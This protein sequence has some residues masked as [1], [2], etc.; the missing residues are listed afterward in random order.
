MTIYYGVHGT[1]KSSAL[2]IEK[3]TEPILTKVGYAGTGF[4]LWACN[5]QKLTEDVLDLARYWHQHCLTTGRYEKVQGSRA[6]A[7]LL[8]KIELDPNEVFTAVSEE[9]REG[10][11]EIKRQVPNK[12]WGE[13]Y[14]DVIN[15]I[16][17][18]LLKNGITL[19]MVEVM[20][21][22][23]PP[24]REIDGNPDEAKV[25][26]VLPA[27]IPQLDPIPRETRK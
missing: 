19:K 23:P 14:N 20:L 17:Q 12:S 18:E 22:T 8:Y 7:P 10:M 13:V 11:E 6:F 24:Y 3:S 5:G 21:P 15:F 9:M 4:Y 1:T 27:G 26:I 2:E 25:Y 16:R